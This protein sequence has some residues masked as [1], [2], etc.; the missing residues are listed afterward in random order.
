VFL[1]VV[2]SDA[3]CLSNLDCAVCDIRFGLVG[4]IDSEDACLAV[5]FFEI[6]VILNSSRIP[7]FTT[8]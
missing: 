4:D 7:S 3:E 1:K 8:L 6:L 2:Y 5:I